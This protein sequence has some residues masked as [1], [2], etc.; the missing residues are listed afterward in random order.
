MGVIITVAVTAAVA[1]VCL[2]II[3]M[4]AFVAAGSMMLY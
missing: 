3:G 4:A 2:W 1:L